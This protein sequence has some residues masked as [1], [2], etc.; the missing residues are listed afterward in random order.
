M[1][2][3]G[4]GLRAPGRKIDDDGLLPT[5]PNGSIGIPCVSWVRAVAGIKAVVS[6]PPKKNKV[7]HVGERNKN[8]TSGDGLW[9]AHPCLYKNGLLARRLQPRQAE[10]ESRKVDTQMACGLQLWASVSVVR[11]DKMKWNHN[12]ESRTHKIRTNTS[13]TDNQHGSLPS[14]CLVAGHGDNAKIN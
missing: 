6:P 13:C 5:S 7:H 4:A 1:Q 12:K 8:Q 14:P 10:R 9:D 3:H 11:R 2:L